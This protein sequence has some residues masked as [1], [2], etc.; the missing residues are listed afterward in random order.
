MPDAA[1]TEPESDRERGLYPKFYVRR[2]DGRDSPGGDREIA[3]RGYFVLDPIFD[4]KAF[5]ALTAYAVVCRQEGYEVL[6]DE[7][8]ANLALIAADKAKDLP[9]DTKIR[10][11]ATWTYE[12][13]PG[14]A[15][16][17]QVGVNA[18]PHLTV[19]EKADLDAEGIAENDLSP[20]EVVEHAQDGSF[21][22]RL[23]ANA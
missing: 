17:E 16:R 13:A 7:I 4:P 19:V 18:A 3:Q 20:A 8:E 21:A 23:I 5:A 1:S 22:M 14:H 11:M 15:Y 6:A 2:V 9:Q 12:A 10:A